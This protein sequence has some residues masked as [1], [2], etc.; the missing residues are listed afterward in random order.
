MPP[1]DIMLNPP[2]WPLSTGVPTLH[3]QASPPNWSIATVLMPRKRTSD[4]WHNPQQNIRSTKPRLPVDGTQTPTSSPTLTLIDIPLTH[5]YTDDT[6]RLH[7]RSRSG[8]QYL[9]VALHGTN[10]ILVQPFSTKKDTHRIAAYQTIYARL[11]LARQA[12]T[13]HIMDN[14]A[15]AAFRQAITNNNCTYQ[16]VPPH[17][18]RRNAAERAIRTFK[19][20]FLAILAGLP[21]S[22]PKDRWDLLLPH[23]ELTLNLL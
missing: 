20:H 9:M 3:G 18:H 21:R 15:S 14:E 13:T 1:P 10:A 22:F 16:L 5:L 11:K 8:N 17:V 19:D 2:G 4:T 6:G 12:P 23:A 7:P